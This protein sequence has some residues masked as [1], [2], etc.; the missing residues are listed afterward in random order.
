LLFPSND[1]TIKDLTFLICDNG[2]EYDA[3]SDSTSPTFD[4]FVFDDEAGNYDV[5]N[6]SGSTVDINLVNNATGYANSYNT[7]G[8]TVT[9]TQAPVTTLIEVKDVNTQSVLQDARVFLK[10]SDGTGDLNYEDT[11]TIT[12]SGTT[13]NVTHTAHGLSTNDWVYIQGA[14]QENYNG[15]YEITVTGANNYTYT[16]TD[17]IVTSPATGTINSTD[18]IFNDLTNASGNVSD[19]RSLSLDQPVE[20]TVRKSSSSPYYKAS[21]V[22]GTINST[23]GLSVTVLLV[24]DE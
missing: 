2:V 20:G 19:T 17:T 21:P 1:A 22:T 14:D 12:G 24:P 7:S 16:T 15:A 3:S 23:A 18:V 9:F 13:A 10:A 5:N 11:V 8:S 6:T 4:N